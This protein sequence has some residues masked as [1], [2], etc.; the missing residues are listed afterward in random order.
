MRES[1]IVPCFS[2]TSGVRGKRKRVKEGRRVGKWNGLVFGE[3]KHI[4]RSRINW[5]LKVRAVRIWDMPPY[6]KTYPHHGME[7]GSKIG[8]SVK[9]VFTNK[10]RNILKEGGI[11][12][13]SGFNVVSSNTS[14]HATNHSYKLT[15]QFNSRVAQSDDDG[16]IHHYGFDFVSVERILSNDL[17]H[18]ILVDFIGR[19]CNISEPQSSSSDPKIKQITLDLEDAQGVHDP[20]P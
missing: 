5:T 15:F 4:H 2:P 10:Y 9:S 14:F 7:M 1:E 12:I 18:N 11:Y 16:S 8:V 19:I 13:I 17:D 6:P 3:V 20:K